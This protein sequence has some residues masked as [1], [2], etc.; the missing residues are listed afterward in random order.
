MRRTLG[1][2]HWLSRSSVVVKANQATLKGFATNIGK[3]IAYDGLEML[4]GGGS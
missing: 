1:I 3:Y 4:A 2:I